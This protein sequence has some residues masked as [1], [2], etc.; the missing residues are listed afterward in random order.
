MLGTIADNLRFNNSDATDEEIK[1]ALKKA[2][3]QFVFDELEDGIDTFVGSLTVMGLSLGKRQRIAIARA[4]INKPKILILDEAT[5]SLDSK[6]QK[7]VLK[8]IDNLGIADQGGAK[9]TVLM[10]ARRL[11]TIETAD[12]LLY[13][14]SPK[15]VICASKGT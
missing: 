1:Q 15:N 6:G 5:S 14:E 2:N 8:A 13:I 3:A 9:L 10:I 12:N 4:L 7:G 11:S